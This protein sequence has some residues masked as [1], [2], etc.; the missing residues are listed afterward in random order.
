MSINRTREI[1]E[2]PGCGLTIGIILVA[3]FAIG[4]FLF[5]QR[6]QNQSQEEG[7]K[8]VVAM[9]G[10]YT[11][12]EDA[13]RNAVESNA[14]KEDS[15]LK[16][17]TDRATALR[18]YVEKGLRILLAR[19]RNIRASDD[20]VMKAAE[21]VTELK[22][23]ILRFRGL[24]DDQIN[25]LYKSRTGKT[26]DELK[27]EDLD[28]V[29]KRLGNPAVRL[30][31]EAEAVAPLLREAVGK[32]L[33]VKDEAVRKANDALVFKGIS[34]EPK[35]GVSAKRGAGQVLAQIQGGMTFE[36]A[37]DKYSAR[38]AEK[39][40]KKSEAQDEQTRLAISN[41]TILKPIGDLKPGQTTGVIESGQSAY[42]FKLVKIK[43][44]SEKD[45]KLN[46]D[47]YRSE[48]V[49]PLAD[50]EVEKL[51]EQAARRVQW[52]SEGYR[53]LYETQAATSG[54]ASK[55]AQKKALKKIAD[56]SAGV[57][58]DVGMDAARDAR[59]IAV[60][61]LWELSSPAERTKLRPLRIEVLQEAAGGD[62]D[63]TLQL[64]GLLME[65]K[66]KSVGQ[67]L[68]EAA[69]TNQD[70]QQTNVDNNKKIVD[71]VAKAKKANLLSPDQEKEIQQV[72]DQWKKDKAAEEEQ[73]RKDAAEEERLRKADEKARKAA[74]QKKGQTKT[75]G[76]LILPPKTAPKTTG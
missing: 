72:L 73:K 19:D 32:G 17:A 14:Q 48:Y 49:R 60:E 65:E 68:L 53:L 67:Y 40:K 69:Q 55:D 16:T 56:E 66:N 58:E 31:F 63:L 57:G 26:F 64:V 39:G 74:E 76:P 50:K 11:V 20:Q 9:I 45:Y 29:K 4:F 34:I 33:P 37:M 43:K 70:F 24:T 7:Q 36:A 46:K 3:V 71:A 5:G 18:Q 59:L 15:M 38:P 1:I 41:N 2:K 6:G 23:T 75:L 8:P 25:S 47:R 35:K 54:N 51:L 21:S 22:R 12:F 13:L 61:K 52:K 44:L 27:R 42:I 30:E 10:E 62:I 28:N